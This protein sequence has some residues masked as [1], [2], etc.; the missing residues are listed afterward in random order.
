MTPGNTNNSADD[1]FGCVYNEPRTK[2]I[3]K[4]IRKMKKTK[5]K[6]RWIKI[7][8]GLYQKLRYSYKPTKKPKKK[9]KPKKKVYKPS[10]LFKGLGS[11][12]RGP[13]RV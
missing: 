11:S 13:G 12:S 8:D 4:K 2:R 1:E 7:G 3:T 10:S 9:R 5:K 6:D